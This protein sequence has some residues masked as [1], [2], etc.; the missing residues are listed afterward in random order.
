MVR[1]ARHL[2]VAFSVL[3]LA[4]ALSAQDRPSERT[5]SLGRP[6]KPA[7]L[8]LTTEP[9]A[10][11]LRLG[12]DTSSLPVPEAEKI[13]VEPLDLEGGTK[14]ALVRATG[15]DATAAALLGRPPGSGPRIL[16]TGRLDPHGDPGERVADVIVSEDRTGDGLPDIVVAS[17]DERSRICGQQRTLLHARVLDPVSLA[18]KPLRQE[19]F[20]PARSGSVVSLKA[21]REASG[22]TSPPLLKALRF[23]SFSSR[24]HDES[25]GAA[26]PDTGDP[27]TDGNPATS[28]VE[29]GG[30]GGKD[31]FATANR[32]ASNWPIKAIA[33]VLAT[34]DPAAAKKL[35]RPKS[36][37][38]VGDDEPP[39]RVTV[40]ED[41]AGNPGGRYWVALPRPLGWKCL[42]VVLDESYPATSTRA[43]AALAEVEVYT[44]LDTGKGAERLVQELA[45]NGKAA[46]EAA[47]LL[48]GMEPDAVA[49][50]ADRLPSMSSQGRR[51]AVR[52]LTAWAAKSGQARETLALA[53]RDSDEDVAR[54]GLRGLL[55]SGPAGFQLVAELVK[56]PGPNG[57]RA[58]RDFARAAPAE[59]LTALLE[60]VSSAGGVDRKLL[61][62]ALEVA[63]ERGAEGV[64]ESISLWAKQAQEPGALAAVALALSTTTKLGETA[65]ELAL[66]AIAR[67][68][69]FEDLWRLVQACRGL[70]ADTQVDGWL[71]KIARNEKRWMLRAAAVEALRERGAPGLRAVALA[72][73][74]DKYPRVRSEAVKAF[75]AGGKDLVLLAA[76]ARKDNWP[77]VRAAAVEG[78]AGVMGSGSTRVLLEAL[79]DPAEVVRAAAV[80]SLAQRK[81]K[82][83]WESVEKRLQDEEEWPVVIAEAIGFARELCLQESAAALRQ[84]VARGIEPGAWEKDVELAAQAVEA[85]ALIGGPEARAAIKAASGADAP[86]LLRA[87]ARRA[88]RSSARCAPP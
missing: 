81:E 14:L 34:S 74:K 52:V 15:R 18:L 75:A 51:R 9:E 32:G 24:R 17:Y 12:N 38:I 21:A 8:I 68:E 54:E 67:A 4:G 36:F 22:F 46:A 84:V 53:A 44:E 85:L 69:S 63:A 27:L 66:Q 25:A 26:E 78:L 11:K 55:G 3:F 43:G 33:L 50:L 76:H 62:E 61:R 1:P 49:L 58:A 57:D 6:A 47:R 73:L 77:M 48:S 40:D 37:W 59:A 56:E 30:A 65:L 79:R 19:P 41:P 60:A 88:G 23:V 82:S 7:R 28:W 70:P 80:R 86:A 10:I 71:E 35:R 72:A 45:E 39:L 5:V 29:A 83:A 2:T 16:W 42:S 31:E 87:T 13:D 20:D 64:R